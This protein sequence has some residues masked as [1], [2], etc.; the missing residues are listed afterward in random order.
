LTFVEHAPPTALALGVGVVLGLAVAWL[1]EPGLGLDAYIGRAVPVRLH[2][3]WV[4]VAAIAGTVVGVIV[5]MVAAS[6]WLARRLEPAEALRIGD[7]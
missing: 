1:T 5:V 4:A 7:A 3:D 6:S 2:I